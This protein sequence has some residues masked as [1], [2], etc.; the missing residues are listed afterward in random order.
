VANAPE[1]EGGSG[2][3]QNSSQTSPDVLKPANRPA[4]KPYLISRPGG[5]MLIA[6]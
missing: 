2:D 4:R 6:A 3:Q 5:G 1:F